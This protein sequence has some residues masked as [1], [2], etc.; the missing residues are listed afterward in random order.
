VCVNQLC[1]FFSLQDRTSEIRSNATN[2][3]RDSGFGKEDTLR[4]DREVEGTSSMAG[5]QR[6]TQSPPRAS[7]DT[8]RMDSREKLEDTQF[9][10]H[11]EVVEMRLEQ[12]S[13]YATPLGIL[14]FILS[15]IFVGI[16]CVFIM[17]I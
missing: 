13:W 17:C 1:V 5:S 4:L 3:I 7:R 16:F 15:H 6:G 10:S 14:S 2:A 8:L 11:P 9:L 12:L